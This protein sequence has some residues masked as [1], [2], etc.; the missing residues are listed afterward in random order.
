MADTPLQALESKIDELIALCRDLNRENQ[1]LQGEKD[2]WLRERQDLINKNELA[3]SK[4]EAMI[5]RLRSME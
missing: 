4:V 5:V 2:G 3:R 1:R